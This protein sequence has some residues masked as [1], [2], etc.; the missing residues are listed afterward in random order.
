M[1]QQFR[2]AAKK[3]FLTYA[4]ATNIESKESLL[5]H[6]KSLHNATKVIVCREEH[7]DEGQHFHALVEFRTRLQ[8][9]NAAYFDFQ[10]HHPNIQVPRRL[11]D[12]LAYIIKDGDYVNDGFTLNAHESITEMVQEAAEL[13]TREEAMRQVMSRGGDRALRLYNQVDGYLGLLQRESTKYE[14]LRQYPEDFKIG[15]PWEVAVMGFFALLLLPQVGER[16]DNHKSLWLYGPSRVGKTQLARS[17]GTHWYMH[18]MWNASALDDTAEY[19]VM[20]DI[21]WESMKFNFRGMLGFQRD[22][23]VTDKYK[24]KTV[25]KGGKGVIV[26]TNEIPEFTPAELEWLN[27]NVIFVHIADKVY[28]VAPPHGDALL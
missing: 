11:Q 16:T 15:E 3:A 4:Q 13:P 12:V 28:N 22:I 27:E 10:G 5:N 14:P 17:L 6:L 19:G 8:S 2:F 20:D 23:T 18:S 24:K 9:R 25:Y 26:C 7:E 1:A 21:M